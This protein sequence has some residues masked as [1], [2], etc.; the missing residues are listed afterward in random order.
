M[1]DSEYLNKRKLLVREKRLNG[2]AA[3][4]GEAGVLMEEQK[5]D[6]P[7]QRIR[8]FA[9]ETRHDLH[10]AMKLLV[11]I[12]DS[13]IVIHGSAGC[14]GAE[15]MAGLGGLAG[16]NWVTTN[17]NERDTIMGSDF[18]L[19]EAILSVY[20]QNRPKLIF[21][22]ATP[23]VA[24]NNDDIESVLLELQ[25]ELDAGL[26][27]V[28]T[29]G[30]STKLGESGCDY[31][32]HAL[33][34]YLAAHTGETGGNPLREGAPS[35]NGAP[36]LNLLAVS[37]SAENIRELAGL[38]AR[39]GF[40]N[41]VF[42]RFSGSVQWKEVAQA[43]YSAPIHEDESDYTGHVLEERFGIPFISAPL[44]V[45]GRGTA[46]WLSRICGSAGL[47]TAWIAGEQLKLKEETHPE[48]LKGLSVYF[49]LSPAYAFGL[50]EFLEE[51]GAETAGF[52]LP[53]L[54]K[55]HG[56]RLEAL[57]LRKPDLK[58]LVGDGQP[59]EEANLLARL[60]PH[61]YIGAGESVGC[62]LRLGIPA[63]DL[64]QLPI[65]GFEG[66][67]RLLRRL[68][69]LLRGPSLARYVSGA[70]AGG[71]LTVYQERWLQRSVNWHIKQEVK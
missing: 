48:Q 53:Y 5:H 66:A 26:I 12:P 33:L 41:L 70:A 43:D 29:D 45:G 34:R 25:E 51:L 55:R 46:E 39:A 13:A 38:T 21:I 17:L 23:V 1:A 2:I 8:T 16:K 58:F 68:D 24:I 14:G 42:P 10:Y 71:Q 7:Y 59:Y 52:K 32:Q 31:A 3:F 63:I 15:R 44:P 18:K 20:A 47:D 56:E 54:D 22:V 28:Y 11:S 50:S 30:F 19:R 69:K 62:A 9:Q 57:S 61:V 67:R 49:N 37:E 64:E 27:P 35:G 6:G 4:Y 60:R 36:V 40:R 65:L